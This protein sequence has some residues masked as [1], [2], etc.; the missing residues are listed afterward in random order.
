MILKTARTI[1]RPWDDGDAEELYKYAKD[2]RV[3]PMAGWPVHTSVSNSLDI[4]RDVLSVPETYAVVLRGSGGPVGSVGIMLPEN[5]FERPGP[6]EAEIGYWLGAPH[7]G[8]GIIPEVVAELVRRCFEELDRE[9]IWCSRFDGNR[10]SQRVQEKCG[11]VPHHSLRLEQPN[12]ANGISI[13]HF[14]RLTRERWLRLAAD[15]N[16]AS[17]PRSQQR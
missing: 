11:F 6:R 16:D 2:E 17:I 14:S 8:Q 15:G 3:G 7:W 13:E 9:L 4:I 5:G 1:L 12:A 10:K